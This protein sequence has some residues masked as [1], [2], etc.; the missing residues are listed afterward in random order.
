MIPRSASDRTV[1][2]RLL[3]QKCFLEYLQRCLSGPQLIRSALFQIVHNPALGIQVVSRRV[4]AQDYII[5]CL[6]SPRTGEDA[7]GFRP[8]KT[9]GSPGA[10]ARANTARPSTSCRSTRN[11]NCKAGRSHFRSCRPRSCSCYHSELSASAM[12]CVHA[13]LSE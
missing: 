2:E 13:S 8:R 12:T 3:P 5:L 10:F 4:E 7:L 9:L 1:L 6:Y 11:A